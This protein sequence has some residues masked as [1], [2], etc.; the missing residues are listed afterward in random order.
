MLVKQLTQ[1]D[2]FSV[3]MQE[4]L[5]ELRTFNLSTMSVDDIPSGRWMEYEDGGNII[6]KGSSLPSVTFE[7][8]N[9]SPQQ[10][11]HY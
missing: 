4:T 6:W 1:V 8:W 7:R 11:E 10:R 9:I 5:F 2:E 3:K